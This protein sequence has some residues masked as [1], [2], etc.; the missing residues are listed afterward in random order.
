EISESTKQRVLVQPPQVRGGYRSLLPR[1]VTGVRANFE[2]TYL[3]VQHPMYRAFVLGTVQRGSLVS[4]PVVDFQ[5]RTTRPSTVSLTP[6][7][8]TEHITVLGWS[9]VK[10]VFREHVSFS[11]SCFP[12]KVLSPD[13]RP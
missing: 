4:L 11:G 12:S 5:S 3:E 9:F 1:P 2:M 7:F 13:I 6:S 8:R 10:R